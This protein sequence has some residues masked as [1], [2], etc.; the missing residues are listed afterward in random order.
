MGTA[1][2]IGVPILAVIGLLIW[3]FA[4]GKDSE[5]GNRAQDEADKRRQDDEI[6]NIPL[7]PS[8]ADELARRLAARRGMRE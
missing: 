5:K 7:E 2:A 3:M 6:D 1:I 4:K 8:D